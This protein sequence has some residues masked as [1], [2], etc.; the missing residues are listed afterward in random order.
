V[1]LS[2]SLKVSRE[3]PSAHERLHP[4]SSAEHA[5][6]IVLGG[7]PSEV[8]DDGPGRENDVCT[9]MDGQACL[10]AWDG[11]SLRQRPGARRSP[12]TGACHQSTREQTRAPSFAR[13]TGARASRGY[14]AKA[15]RTVLPSRS[16]LIPNL[17]EDQPRFLDSIHSPNLPCVRGHS[18]VAPPRAQSAW[19]IS[20]FSR[21]FTAGLEYVR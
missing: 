5:G 20:A 19:V 16:T 2:S 15:P 9:W 6:Q 21:A 7:I 10:K 18:T 11:L 14:P 17:L 8:A 4:K 13:S 1:L 3:S 12:L